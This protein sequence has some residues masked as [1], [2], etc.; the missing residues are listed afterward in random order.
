MERLLEDA[1]VFKNVKYDF[2]HDYI[3]KVYRRD[4]DDIHFVMIQEAASFRSREAGKSVRINIMNIT[5]DYKE[6]LNFDFTGVHVI[7]SSF[8]DEVFAK[9]F[10]EIGERRFTKLFSF[11]NIEE[12]VMILINRS[13][14]LRNKSSSEQQSD[15]PIV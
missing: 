15:I 12:T 5:D 14:R 9:I 1:F 6:K 13:I 2:P 7:S 8:A 11:M 3:D 4:S 10:L